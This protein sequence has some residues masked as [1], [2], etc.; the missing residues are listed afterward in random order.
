MPIVPSTARCASVRSVGSDDAQ[1]PMNGP[2][3]NAKAAS[4][5]AAAATAP[6]VLI[7]AA[8]G[9][10][11]PRRVASERE[12]PDID[13][14]PDGRRERQAGA[15]PSSETAAA[16]ASRLTPMPAKDAMSGRRRILPANRSSKPPSGS[17]PPPAG[18][19][20]R[21]PAPRPMPPPT[22]ALNAPRMNS[23][24]I[25]RSGSTRNATKNGADERHR[26]REGAVLRMH[27]RR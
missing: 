10:I 9:F 26:E 16:S 4:A 27:A 1:R 14:G 5:R 13:P 19:R 22:S 8:S 25:T 11:Q 15:R 3:I 12:Q 2:A 23:A 21:P 20:H 6:S 24:D 18:P 7:N 17:A